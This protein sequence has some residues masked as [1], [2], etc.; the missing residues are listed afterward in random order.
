MLNTFHYRFCDLNIAV[1]EEYPSSIVDWFRQSH[2]RLYITGFYKLH[3]IPP[4][5][6]SLD[7]YSRNFS[8]QNREK[9]NNFNPN[10]NILNE[11]I[12][13]AMIGMTPN[14]GLISNGLFEKEVQTT[15]AYET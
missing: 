14:Y 2:S 15:F 3:T 6:S 12:Q 7:S 4:R 8:I 13:S 9:S 11:Q 5:R 1:I 10:F